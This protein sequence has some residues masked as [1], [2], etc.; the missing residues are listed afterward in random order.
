MHVN[1]KKCLLSDS[2]TCTLMVFWYIELYR[3][4]Y[5]EVTKTQEVCQKDSR[6][7]M[8]TH[9]KQL[10]KTSKANRWVLIDINTFRCCNPHIYC[11]TVANLLDIT[12]RQK[13]SAC[14]N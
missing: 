3:A 14:I 2:D 1:T 13:T 4:V 8:Y 12:T 9:E 6:K 7:H 11:K 10:S 5:V